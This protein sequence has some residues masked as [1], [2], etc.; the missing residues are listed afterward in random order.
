M[1]VWPEKGPPERR[2]VGRFARVLLEREPRM[3]VEEEGRLND[4]RLREN[5]IERIFAYRRL[6]TLFGGRWRTGDLVAFHARHKLQLLAHSPERY[7][8]L[9]RLVADA[10]ALPRAELRDRYVD[11]FMEALAKKATPGRHVNVMQHMI[12]YFRKALD[13]SDIDELHDHVTDYRAGHAPLLVP[14]TLIRHHARRLEVGYL[15]QQLY[16]DPHP[17]ELLLR[18]HV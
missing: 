16:L 1:P 7:R 5:W 9:G 3:P 6:H 17:K 11:G 10:K 15:L 8:T 13:K 18:N 2:G 14:L 12:G 4:A